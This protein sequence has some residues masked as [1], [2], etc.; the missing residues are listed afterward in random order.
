MTLPETVRALLPPAAQPKLADALAAVRRLEQLDFP[1]PHHA[2]VRILRNLTCEPLGPLLRLE[3]FRQLLRIDVEF[4]DYDTYAQEILAPDSP[5]RCQPFDII[6]LALALDYLPLAFD[7]HQALQAEAVLEHVRAQVGELR[8]HTGALIAIN[9]FLLP[10][11]S[12]S[13]REIAALARLNAGLHGL[14]EPDG[15]VL[16]IDFGQIVEQLG[17][18]SA[19]DAR[20]LFTYKSPLQPAALQ[21]WAA[22]LGAALASQ[23]GLS[24]KVLALDCDGTLWGGIIGEDGL[25]GIQ[26]HPHESP[27]NIHHT[28]QRQLLQLQQ[29]GV[30]L[31][32]CSKNNESDVLEVL[33]THPYSVLRREH[34]AA[35]R[36]DWENKADNLA[37]LAQ[38]LNIGL[39]A[40]VFVDDSPAECD[41]VRQTLPAVEVRQVPE[42]I[43]LLPDLLHHYFGF[44]KVA[45]TDED[46]QRTHSYQADRKRR[47]EAAQ[48]TNLEEYLAGLE[49]VAEIGPATEDEIARIAQ[50]TLRTNQFNLTTRRYSAGDLERLRQSPDWRVLMMKVRDKFGD[51]G[52][53]ATAILVR[54][55]THARIDA[56]LLS[57]RILGRRLEDALLAETIRAAQTFEGVSQLAAEFLPTAKNAQV[58]DFFAQRGFMLQS[59]DAPQKHYLLDL[60]QATIR[61]ADFITIKRRSQP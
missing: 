24:K 49:L 12:V 7:S 28:F 50:L 57:C 4:G 30:L 51:Y 48:T 35:W 6:V 22:Q 29:Q 45:A 47:T 42:R 55:K 16:A 11:H 14:A 59:G 2:R 18:T 54:E 41:F 36:I 10:S 56:F 15:R 39:D 3:G 52:L 20:Y 21:S 61:H 43:H 33:D 60:S 38:E 53:T 17:R 27:G 32:L 37:A 31:V 40:F 44:F 8:Q 34:L 13:P 25:A 19:V 26:L 9:T 46:A 5:A 1:W 58:S 23:K